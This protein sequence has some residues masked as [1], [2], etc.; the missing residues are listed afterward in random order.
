MTHSEIKLSDI[1]TP[2]SL[3][4][5]NMAIHTENQANITPPISSVTLPSGI[6]FYNREILPTWGD[7]M[8]ND[9]LQ[10]AE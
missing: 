4:T 9:L 7:F 10:N 5:I 3:K 6:D 8:N 1:K 2:T